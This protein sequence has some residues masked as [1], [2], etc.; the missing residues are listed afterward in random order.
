MFILQLTYH[1]IRLIIMDIIRHTIILMLRF[2]LEFILGFML[3]IME[4]M[5]IM[6][7]MGIM[8]TLL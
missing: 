1:I 4:D 8:A 3:L 6:E 5:D 2:P 7:D